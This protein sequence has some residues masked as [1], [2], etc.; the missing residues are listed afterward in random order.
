MRDELDALLEEEETLE[1]ELADLLASR[2]TYYMKKDGK[3]AG[4]RPAGPE[5]QADPAAG[6]EEPAAPSE[7]RTE[8]PAGDGEKGAGPWMEERSPAGTAERERG[9]TL[10][11]LL[12][13][14]IFRVKAAYPRAGKAREARAESVRAR[15]WEAKGAEPARA[16]ETGPQAWDTG[17]AEELWTESA[18]EIRT[19]RS[20]SLYG[21]LART[22]QAARYRRPAAGQK[23]SLEKERVTAEGTGLAAAD[24]DKLFQRD[25]RRYDGGFTWL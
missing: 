9:F 8:E 15:I 20:G 17:T 3:P 13:K 11:D 18:E 4:E 23:V 12:P 21:E 22:R 6:S 16:G 25:A 5:R 7:V 1:A 2:V 24:L 10:R 14:G 19:A